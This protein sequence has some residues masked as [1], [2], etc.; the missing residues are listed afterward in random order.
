MRA[1]YGWRIPLNHGELCGCMANTPESWEAFCDS[2]TICLVDGLVYRVGGGW[3][4][5]EGGRWPAAAETNRGRKLS[6]HFSRA[7]CETREIGAIQDGIGRTG[8]QKEQGVGRGASRW[9]QLRKLMNRW[10]QADKLLKNRGSMIQ[11]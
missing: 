11:L 10:R 5:G 1:V 8:G 2:K 6:S 9:I 4:V 7:L 3:G